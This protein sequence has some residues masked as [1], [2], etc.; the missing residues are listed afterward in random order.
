MF[1]SYIYVDVNDI[2]YGILL[3]V[4]LNYFDF[5][6]FDCQKLCI[7]IFNFQIEYLFKLCVNW[8]KEFF[9]GYVMK[10]LIFV[11]CCLG[12]LYSYIFS[13][14]NNCVFDVGGGCCVCESWND[15]V[16]YLFY[17]LFGLNDLLFVLILFGGDVVVQ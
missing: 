1:V 14:N 7:G 17:V 11:I 16:G 6:V 2:G 13:E 5:V 4:M 3:M 8:E 10:V 12:Q 15:D 9:E